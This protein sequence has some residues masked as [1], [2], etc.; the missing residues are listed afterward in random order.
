MVEKFDRREN[1]VR[2]LK[3]QPISVIETEIPALAKALGV[4]VKDILNLAGAASEFQRR[5]EGGGA[6]ECCGNDSW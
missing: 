4:D 6:A 1:S 2:D 5:A 3:N